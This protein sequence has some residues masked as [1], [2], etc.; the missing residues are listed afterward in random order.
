MDDDRNKDEGS[1]QKG[2]DGSKEMGVH[3]RLGEGE[4][5]RKNMAVEEAPCSKMSC[6]PWRWSLKRIE[7]S[8]II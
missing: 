7:R 6:S 4:E 5:R 8:S 2:S 3:G 1:E